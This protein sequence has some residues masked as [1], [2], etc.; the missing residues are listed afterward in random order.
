[1]AE[2][3]SGSGLQAIS[4][5]RI[6][7]PAVFNLSWIE[8]NLVPRIASLFGAHSGT[9]LSFAGCSSSIVPH[10]QTHQ[11]DCSIPSTS[12]RSYL[13]PT[14]CFSST[15][16]FWNN[17]SRLAVHPSFVRSGLHPSGPL[18]R[19]VSSSVRR[20][21]SS[22]VEQGA[23]QKCWSCDFKAPPGA[24]LICPSC[25]AVQPLDPAVDHFQIFDV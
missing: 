9:L 19:F 14:L 10:E 25:S 5:L 17:P 2:R 23:T 20:K 8:S 18:D 16:G 3:F 11:A 15:C 6:L 12:S 1:M 7:D 24:F 22:A 13:P 4:K 21:V